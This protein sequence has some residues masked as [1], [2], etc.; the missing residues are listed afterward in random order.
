MFVE[1]T[2]NEALLADSEAETWGDGTGDVLVV[3][4]SML[5][6]G[7]GGTSGSGGDVERVTVL[8]GCADEGSGGDTKLLTLNNG[9]IGRACKKLIFIKLKA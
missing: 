5:S 7:D 3:T 9:L 1:A 6:W 4:T 8:A 2:F